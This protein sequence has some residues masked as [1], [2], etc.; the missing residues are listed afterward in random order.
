[1]ALERVISNRARS[2]ARSSVPH[3]QD[4]AETRVATLHRRKSARRSKTMIGSPSQA[5]LSRSS[6]LRCEQYGSGGADNRPV[7][8][9]ALRQSQSRHHRLWKVIAS[10]TGPA[11]IAKSPVMRGLHSNAL[12]P[13]KSSGDNLK[14]A[15]G[16][17]VFP[18]PESESC[19]ISARCGH[20]TSSLIR[21]LSNRSKL[22]VN[23]VMLGKQR[24]WSY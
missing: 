4:Q 1:M 21:R 18:S 20:Q 22:F 23:F 6:R 9:V 16:A 24:R 3:R 12:T 17:V 10:A 11:K 8:C 15:P 19:R 14:R 5:S 7:F 13:M 2:L